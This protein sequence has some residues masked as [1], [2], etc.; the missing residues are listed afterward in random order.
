M[1]R[2][3]LFLGL[4]AAFLFAACTKE[5]P[6]ERIDNRTAANHRVSVEEALGAADHHYGNSMS[7]T[8]TGS[9]NY[10]NNKQLLTYN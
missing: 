5:E 6:M 1:K 4:L 7:G 9:G 3:G 10:S 8:E 2:I